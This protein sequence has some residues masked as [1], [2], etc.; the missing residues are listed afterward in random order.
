[1]RVAYFDLETTALEADIGHILIG[2]ILCH[3]GEMRTFRQDEMRKRGDKVDCD[4][5]IAV[6]IR[7]VLEEH[8]IVVGWHSKGFDIPFLNTR[9]V[10][11]GQQPIRKHLHFDPRW[12]MAGWRGLKPRN[13][14]LETAAEFFQLGE[15][16]M[17][18]P[19]QTWSA[20]RY[21]DREALDVLVDRCESDVL[22][23]RDLTEKILDTGLVS[24]IQSYP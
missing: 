2:S 16:K 12:N 18:V 4:K 14:R 13:A 19:I 8:H 22:L 7:D 10:A 21:L 17:K 6:A 5:R 1:L 23:L 15:Q 24:N 11:N 20:S 3:D 9:L